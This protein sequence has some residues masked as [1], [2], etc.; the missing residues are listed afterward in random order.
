MPYSTWIN[1]G[2]IEAT[3]GNVIDYKAIMARLIELRGMYEIR[4]I[5]YDRWGS[6]QLIRDMQDEGL[7]VV[8]LGQGFASMTAP[9][10]ELMNCVLMR[11]VRHDGNPVMRWMASNMVVQQDA[12]GNLKP[13]KAKSSEKIDGMVA[14]IMALDRATRKA[15]SVYEERGIEVW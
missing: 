11:R 4:E 3:S 8:P 5:A 9:T 10:K 6:T 13:D 15:E 14:L 7:E 1:L 12:A 2:L